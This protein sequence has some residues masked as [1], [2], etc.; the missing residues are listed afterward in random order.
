[1]TIF[2][3]WVVHPMDQGLEVLNIQSAVLVLVPVLN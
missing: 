1:M 2:I 3:K